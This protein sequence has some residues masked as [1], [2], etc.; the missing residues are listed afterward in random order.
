MNRREFV[1]IG[2][3]VTALLAMGRL[4]VLARTGDMLPAAVEPVTGFLPGYDPPTQRGLRGDHRLT[5]DLVLWQQR[6]PATG[7]T[8]NGMA[9]EV[10]VERVRVPEGVRYSID[11]IRRYAAVENRLTARLT[12]APDDL[13]TLRA[14]ESRASWR[15]SR[16]APPLR[17]ELAPLSSG[18]RKDG[19]RVL[20]SDGRREGSERPLATLWSL[21]DFIARRAGP[22]TDVS[23]DLLV[24]LSHVSPD[25]RL[26]YD[27]PVDVA[28]AHGRRLRCATYL[29][30]GH[31]ILP[32]HYLVDDRGLPQL[33]TAS[34]VSY[35]LREVEAVA[36]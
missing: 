24:D 10:I 4:P 2:S 16:A 11:E 8:Q 32:T 18:G 23:L 6:A 35:A 27:G 21:T 25:A 34:M 31:G 3:A 20:H 7:I 36:T 30:T 17:H 19:D 29:L 14:W 28:V 12:C 26:R 22:A 9:G 5:Y 33:V 13:R 15:P 1:R